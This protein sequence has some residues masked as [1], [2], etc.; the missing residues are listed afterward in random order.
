MACAGRKAREP[1]RRFQ[2]ECA[3]PGITVNTVALPRRTATGRKLVV[4][5]AAL[6]NSA[7]HRDR[8]SSGAPE[9]AHQ[10]AALIVTE[11]RLVPASYTRVRQGTYATGGQ[12]PSA[13]ALRAHLA[14]SA[15]V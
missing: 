3:R 7:G 1:D 15:A 10:A 12:S 6:R 11:G 4:P 9:P 14:H 5:G 13:A 2:W 8:F